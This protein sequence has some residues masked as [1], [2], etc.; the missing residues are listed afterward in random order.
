MLLDKELH[1][2][3]AWAFARGAQFQSFKTLGKERMA[4]E[5]AFDTR[6]YYGWAENRASQAAIVL[7]YSE[8]HH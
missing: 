3:A 8:G 7:Y 4:N 5:D 6:T 2:T 1:K